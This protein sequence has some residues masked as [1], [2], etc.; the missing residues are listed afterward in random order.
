MLV[1]TTNGDT[2]IGRMT[3]NFLAQDSTLTWG[4]EVLSFNECLLKVR[5][6]L[7]T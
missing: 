1:E 4:Q 2:K 5:K 6:I 3:M 7:D